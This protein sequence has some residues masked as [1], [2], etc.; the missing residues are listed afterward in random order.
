[1][2]GAIDQSI[3]AGIGGFLAFFFLAVA[4][5][6]LMRNMNSRLRNVHYLEEAEDERR[7]MEAQEPVVSRPPAQRPQ[8]N[9]SVENVES[10]QENAGP[11]D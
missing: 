7:A 8:E 10:P 2:G 3:S 11:T 4:L 5:W 1:M 9:P 6:L